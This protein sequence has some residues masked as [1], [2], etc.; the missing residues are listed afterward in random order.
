MISHAYISCMS[1]RLRNRGNEMS[2]N[3][4]TN[5]YQSKANVKYFI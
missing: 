4:K 3:I 5:Y 2:T 1:V